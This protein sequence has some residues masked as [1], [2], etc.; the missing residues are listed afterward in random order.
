M[1]TS[2]VKLPSWMQEKSFSEDSHNLHSLR[3][4]VGFWSKLIQWMQKLSV[5]TQLNDAKHLTVE[6]CTS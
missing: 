1:I 4:D 2:G 5:N 3:N 6:S